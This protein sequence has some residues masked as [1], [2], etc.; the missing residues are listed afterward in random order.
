MM[1]ILQ[2]FDYDLVSENDSESDKE[3]KLLKPLNFL[4]WQS[5]LLESV[6]RC[7]VLTVYFL[8][9]S[10]LLKMAFLK[11]LVIIVRESI[12][13]PI[14]WLQWMFQKATVSHKIFLINVRKVSR[15]VTY[16]LLT[17]ELMNLFSLTF[18]RCF[19][20]WF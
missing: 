15:L 10:I 17:S 4:N 1:K 16:Y 19:I 6:K 18:F 3:W 9:W 12:Q 14:E 5:D 7:L 11:T 13:I 20:Q 8:I 2:I